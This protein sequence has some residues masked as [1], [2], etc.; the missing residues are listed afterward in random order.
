MVAAHHCTGE[1]SMKGIF[2]PRKPTATTPAPT[3]VF[4]SF[5]LGDSC[6]RRI[7]RNGAATRAICFVAPAKPAIKSPR[8][9][10]LYHSTAPPT[11]KKAQTLSVQLAATRAGKKTKGTR[12]RAF[13]RE[14]TS[15]KIRRTDKMWKTKTPSRRS[16]S[17]A[18]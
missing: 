13:C 15:P 7:R 2:G 14:G 6:E 1:E 12:L 4:L 9:R 16:C 11:R 17:P 3:R 5:E 10:F 8:F 18:A